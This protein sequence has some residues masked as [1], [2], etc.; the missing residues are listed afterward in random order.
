[1][2]PRIASFA[3]A[4]ALLAASTAF[5][6][7]PPTQA[8][9][10]ARA[11]DAERLFR[12][13]RAAMEAGDLLHAC[14][15][16]AESEKLDPAPGTLL[17][18]ADCEERAKSLIKARE[19]YLL[20]ASGFPKKDP[21]RAF[22]AGRAQSLEK[23]TAH[24][25]LHLP[26]GAPPETTVRIGDTVVPHSD[27]GTA[28]TMDPVES[29]VTVSAPGRKD[30]VLVI[31]LVEGETKDVVCDLGAAVEAA[32]VVTAP[33]APVVGPE[34]AAPAPNAA[35][36]RRTVAYVLLGVGA[37]SLIAGGVTGV[38]AASK[39]STVKDHCDASNA[40]DQDGVD[41]AASGRFLAPFSTV[42]VIAGAALAGAGVY[43]YLAS[44]KSHKPP[45]A[46]LLHALQL[47][48]SF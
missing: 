42:T 9:D 46:A 32:R 17:S 19:H 45:P 24:L 30:N 38:L 43:F 6:Q 3:L 47:R 26:A 11:A 23:R 14:P 15:K 31:S 33:V 21:R 1:M 25:V 29:R 4:S 40:C 8:P 5:A 22:A 7:A 36:P 20:A 28:T 27:L 12:E 44:T 39:A 18:L 13:G 10:A 41:A 2:R 37:A 48:G 16:F 35:D 34:R